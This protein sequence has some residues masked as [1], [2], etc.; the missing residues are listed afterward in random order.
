M[1]EVSDEA[2]DVDVG[3]TRA[4]AR[5]GLGLEAEPLRAGL[6]PGMALPLL[7]VVAQ[8]AAQRPRGRQPLRGELER[9]FVERVEMAASPR[10]SVISV[11]RRPARASS[12]RT[13]VAF[14]VVGE[15]PVAVERAARLLDDTHALGHH[16]QGGRRRDDPGG[17]ERQRVARQVRGGERQEAAQAVVEDEHRVLARPPRRRRPRLSICC[18]RLS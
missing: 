2:R 13:G 15:L 17:G 4:V 1:A 11:T 16:H 18:R 12:G 8:G 6:A 9:D 10:P 5:R 14:G 3:R 7:A